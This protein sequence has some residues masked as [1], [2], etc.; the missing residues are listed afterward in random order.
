MCTLRNMGNDLKF[1]MKHLN[2]ANR[3]LAPPTPRAE[4]VLMSLGLAEIKGTK[5]PPR[6]FG[7]KKE[8]GGKINEQKE[9]FQNIR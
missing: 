9:R 2:W 7:A 6:R 1:V 8:H 4:M 3:T 5:S